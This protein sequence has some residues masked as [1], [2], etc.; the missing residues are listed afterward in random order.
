M[1]SSRIDTD[2]YLRRIGLGVR[3]ALDEKGLRVVQVAHLETV[4]FE[5]LDILSGRPLSLDLGALE[6]KV[7]RGRRGGFC[8]E[9][10]GLLAVLLEQ[11]GVRVTRFAA[12]TW[13][14]DSESWGPPFDHLVLRVDLDR[15][16]L[17][18][19]GFGD[20]FREP[21]PLVDGAEQ[22]DP[23]GGTFGLAR[24][25]GR[26]LVWKRF[27]RAD[28]PTPLFRFDEEPHQLADF[29]AMCRWQET[30]S[31]FFTGHRIVERMTPHG[32]LVLYD[33]RLITHV[34]ANRSERQVPEPEIAG[35]LKELFGI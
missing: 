31:S 3:P 25:D 29:N 33:N 7:I 12:E 6:A 1:M 28:G 20:S 16:W 24:A 27:A 9:L 17:V 15:P 19:F 21:L 18:D 30:E 8:Y 22:A 5:N 32:R 2:S 4:P 11:L 14:Q 26:W 13:S 34:G 10:N 23:S 35:L